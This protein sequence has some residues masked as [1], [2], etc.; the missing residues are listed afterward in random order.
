MSAAAEKYHRGVFASR[1][2]NRYILRGRWETVCGRAHRERWVVVE[3]A[4][5]LCFA[6]RD[7]DH[8]RAM[9]EWERSVASRPSA[10]QRLMMLADAAARAQSALSGLAVALIETDPADLPRPDSPGRVSVTI[11]AW[12]AMAASRAEVA[13]LIAL[14][15][16]SD[17]EGR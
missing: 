14:A 7:A 16:D 5:N 12:N 10:E 3:V 15:R 2:I 4:L 11:E 17:V 1:C 8:C 13:A 6:W 9:H